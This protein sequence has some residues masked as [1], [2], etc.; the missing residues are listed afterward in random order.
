MFI[1]LIQDILYEL[2]ETEKLMFG[3]NLQSSS[4]N[5]LNESQ[6]VARRLLS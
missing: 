4:G 3:L 1:L 2:L 5:I 6:T